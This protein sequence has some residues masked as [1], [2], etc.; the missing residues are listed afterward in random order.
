M[1]HSESES[2]KIQPRPSDSTLQ[3]VVLH[4]SLLEKNKCTS[5]LQ[6]TSQFTKR[7]PGWEDGL[8]S[9]VISDAQQKHEALSGTAFF[10]NLAWVM[11]S[12]RHSSWP[13]CRKEIEA[14]RLRVSSKVMQQRSV[15]SRT[16]PQR[17]WHN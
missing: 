13:F 17:C 16:Q 5:E 7:F 6:R 1:S 10:I 3:T 12:S 11:S 4:V 2:H 14:V 9:C 15:R 8:G